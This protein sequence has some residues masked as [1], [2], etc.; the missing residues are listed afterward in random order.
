MS[1]PSDFSSLK[2]ALAEWQDIDVTAYY[3]GQCLGLIERNVSFAASKPL[4]LTSNS[5]SHVIY[6]ILDALVKLAAVEYDPEE[7][8]YR[9]SSTFKLEENLIAQLSAPPNGGPA[10]QI[11]NSGVSEGP[12]SVS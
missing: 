1:T 8:R 3:V 7:M 9:W 5:V 12:P 11:G 6:D 4:V 10:T 2:E